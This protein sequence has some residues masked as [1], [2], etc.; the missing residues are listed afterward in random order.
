M[1]NSKLLS[2]LSY[3]SVF[4]APLLVPF[5]IWLLADS[6]D[7]KYHSKRALFSHLIPTILLLVASLISFFRFFPLKQQAIDSMHIT[8]LTQSTP[9]IS[10]WGAAPFLFMFMYSFL[11]L[12]VLIWSV[13]Q[14][15]KVFKN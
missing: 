10:F 6:Q 9:T 8:N 13:V 14:G 2:S 5:V 15:V 1:N 12:I 7:V 4:F 11:F 3:F